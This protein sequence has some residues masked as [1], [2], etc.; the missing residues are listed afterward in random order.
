MRKHYDFSKGVVNPYM[1]LL[2]R[3]AKGGAKKSPRQRIAE[4]EQELSDIKDS[5]ARTVN[6]KCNPKDDRVHCTCVPWLRK[7][8]KELEAQLKGI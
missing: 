1:P 5:Y 7:R 3:S 8:I 6:E 4:L 2:K